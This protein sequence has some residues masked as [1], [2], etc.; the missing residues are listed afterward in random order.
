MPSEITQRLMLSNHS[1]SVQYGSTALT[2]SKRSR[3]KKSRHV[4]TRARVVTN[5]LGLEDAQ[6]DH[7]KKKRKEAAKYA[8]KAATQRE[9]L[10]RRATQGSTRAF[11]CPLGLSKN[12]TELEDIAHAAGIDILGTTAQLLERIT[13][14]FND[15]PR[16]KEV[17]SNRCK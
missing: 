8:Q 10:V 13:N 14:H 15:H 17:L 3:G 16:F 12:K 6:Q 2:R 1:A 5:D 11:V 7:D 9:D 4:H